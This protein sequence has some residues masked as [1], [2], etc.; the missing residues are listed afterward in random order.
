MGSWYLK[1]AAA[2]ADWKPA[3]T[4]IRLEGLGSPEKPLI[5]TGGIWHNLFS[6]LPSFQEIM[7]VFFFG[8]S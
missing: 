5:L 3:Q 8:L 6:D 7:N 4:D 1:A 2:E